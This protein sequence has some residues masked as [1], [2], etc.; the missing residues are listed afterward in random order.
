MKHSRFLL[1]AVGALAL[2]GAAQAATFENLQ[3]SIA[4]S[5]PVRNQ[6]D[7]Y[8]PDGVSNAPVVMWIHG[9]GWFFGDKAN[10]PGL[11]ALLD[12][13]IAVASMNYRYSSET[14]WPGQLEDV[15]NAFSFVRSN[16]LTYG[17]DATRMASFGASAGGH[18][19]AWAGL[20]LSNQP[21]TA[22]KA[23]VTWFPPTDLANM[24]ADDDADNNPLDVINHNGPTSP[25]TALIGGL[26][27]ENLGLADAASP[28]VYAG[29][30]PDGQELPSFLLMHGDMDP[31]VSYLQSQRLYD[32]IDAQ[33]GS[34]RLELMF[35]AGAGHGGQEFYDNFDTVVNFLS[36]ELDATPAVPLPASLPLAIAGFG[37]LFGMRRL[38]RKSDA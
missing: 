20:D 15:R 30:L 19:A 22:L 12:A 31:L 9:G 2:S 34:P 23:T 37:A 11:D 18:L 29:L 5:D 17:Y 24:D 8:T 38:N 1:A 32:A 7:I 26:P 27:Q 35:L 14:T 16:G 33:G 10:P 21:A 6:L 13:G 28:A 4:S 3:Y 36:D 25:E